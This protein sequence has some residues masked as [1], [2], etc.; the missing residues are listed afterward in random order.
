MPRLVIHATL[1]VKPDLAEE[2]AEVLKRV[3]RESLA[4]PGT[5]Y[6]VGTFASSASYS[7]SCLLNIAYFEPSE[8]LGHGPERFQGLRDLPVARSLRRTR[9]GR[10]PDHK[11]VFRRSRCAYGTSGCA[12][13]HTNRGRREGY[14]CL[15][16]A[17][18]A[19]HK[20]MV[21]VYSKRSKS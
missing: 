6:Y 20:W 3:M 17:V 10:L 12:E 18:D 13:V 16:C 8:S 5:E 11:E 2:C 1:R 7:R 9:E 19:D 21:N 15:K 4:E 14:C